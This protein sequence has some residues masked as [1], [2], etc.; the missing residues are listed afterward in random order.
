[1]SSE[2][3]RELRLALAL[4]R[5]QIDVKF[6]DNGAPANHRDYG[7]LYE[8]LIVPDDRT[9]P[10]ANSEKVRRP[11]V[12]AVVL[13]AVAWA[14]VLFNVSFSLLSLRLCLRRYLPI[15]V[16][17]TIVLVPFLSPLF[18]SRLLSFVYVRA[19]V[20]TFVPVC[21]PACVLSVSTYFS[22][23]MRAFR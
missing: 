6:P 10:A 15:F 22:C 4:C 19:C 9:N 8:V 12:R 13:G 7:A 20:S 23:C 17:L 11:P 1:M 21:V 16:C 3:P 2:L 5:K 18:S 14:P